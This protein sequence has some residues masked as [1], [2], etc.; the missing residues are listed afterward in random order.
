MSNALW[1]D[2][3]DPET[4]VK[5]Q[6]GHSFSDRD[7]DMQHFRNTHTVK[8]PT[9]NSYGRATYQDRE[10]ITTEMHVCGY[11]WRKQ[12]P[13]DTQPA[14]IAETRNTCADIAPQKKRILMG[15]KT[16]DDD[17]DRH[18]HD[19]VVIQDVKTFEH[20]ARGKP[21]RTIYYRCSKCGVTRT[22][23]L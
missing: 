3:N 22:E 18:F 1:C 2:I 4:N 6:I 19:W 10:E 7:E 9:G 20:G 11:H 15:K 21:T 17:G 5:G 12:N 23:T 14:A 8:V 13:F 16:K